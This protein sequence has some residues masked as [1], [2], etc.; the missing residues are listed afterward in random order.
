MCNLYEGFHNETGYRV[1]ELNNIE[2][3]AYYLRTIQYLSL[4][5][6]EKVNYIVENLVKYTEQYK[7]DFEEY[8]SYKAEK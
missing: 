6:S 1:L 5:E 8:I 2:T 4:K 3:V 7:K